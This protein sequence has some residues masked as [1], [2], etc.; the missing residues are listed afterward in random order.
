MSFN[1]STCKT[2]WSYISVP[3][4]PKYLHLISFVNFTV[5]N[6]I[7]GQRPTQRQMLFNSR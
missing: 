7:G 3:V 6:K 5:N 2:D 4:T 1:Y